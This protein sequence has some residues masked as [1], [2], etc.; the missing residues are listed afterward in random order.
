MD[1]ATLFKLIIELISAIAKLLWPIIALVIILI[2]RKDIA[3]LLT[4]VRKGKLFGQEVELDP[5]MDEFRKRVGEAQSEIPKRKG[6]ATL[7]GYPQ[8]WKNR[9]C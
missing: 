3:A 8:G 9:I 2:F 6:D 4:R 7:Y 5:S 1:A